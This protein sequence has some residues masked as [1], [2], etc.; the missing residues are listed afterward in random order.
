M[1][2]FRA[3]SFVL[4]FAIQKYG[5]E[6]NITVTLPDVLYGCDTLSLT[7]SEEH[8]LRVFENMVLRKI[9]GPMKDEMTCECRRIHNEEF[10]DLYSS[11]NIIWATKLRRMR[12]AGHVA[13]LGDRRGAYRV[14]VGIPDEKRLLGRPVCRWEVLMG[15]PNEKRPL[16]RPVCRWEV[17]MGIPDEKRP[18]GRPVCRWEVLMGYLMKRDRLEDL[19][20]DG[21]F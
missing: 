16:G 3:K 10:Y 11:P 1:L 21:R 2:K 6:I 14:L 13:R 4:Q 12:W 19:C 15:I 8:K 20:V 17:L 5:V 7:V 9:F 18:L